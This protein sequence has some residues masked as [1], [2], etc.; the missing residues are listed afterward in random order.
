MRQLLTEEW[1][2][3]V[4]K[5]LNDLRLRPRRSGDKEKTAQVA[6]LQS[7]MREDKSRATWPMIGLVQAIFH[8]SL[9]AGFEM[10]EASMEV[11]G[12]DGV[13]STDASLIDRLMQ[14]NLAQKADRALEKVPGL[15]KYLEK[16]ADQRWKEG[17]E[18][19]RAGS[20]YLELYS[21]EELTGAIEVLAT[22][23]GYDSAEEM[24][25]QDRPP[26]EIPKEVGK[27]YL[28]QLESYIA[29][30]LTPARLDQLRGR[31]DA[32][33]G[34]PAFKGE[35]LPF[36][37]MLREYLQD[38]NAVQNEMGF[39]IRALFGEMSAADRMASENV[40]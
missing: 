25:A 16:Q 39:L 14:S 27:A 30:L 3:D 35:W 31:M 33:L 21:L 10:I 38:D 11:M 5:G 4:L 17:L 36:V 9:M 29:E 32:V 12:P 22:L 13:E 18:A 24:T 20:L 8:S 7:F 2:Q 40:V 37:V 6:T 34:D 28:A 19:I 15:K 23:I 1:C 26:P